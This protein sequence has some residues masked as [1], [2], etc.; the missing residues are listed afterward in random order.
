MNI[1][2]QT[3][4]LVGAVFLFGLYLGACLTKNK[5]HS[6]TCAIRNPGSKKKQKAWHSTLFW[7]CLVL[8]FRS[9]SWFFML[10]G[11]F[12]EPFYIEGHADK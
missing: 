5:F 6:A 2:I 1:W 7:S 9:F 12:V 8:V 4:I 10:A 11:Q 3:L